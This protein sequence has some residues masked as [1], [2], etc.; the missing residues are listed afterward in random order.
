MILEGDGLQAK[1]KGKIEG[2]T[3][4]KSRGGSLAVGKYLSRGSDPPPPPLG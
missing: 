1:N 2:W 4:L 3:V